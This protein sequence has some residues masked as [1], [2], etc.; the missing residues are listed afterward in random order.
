MHTSLVHP[1]ID[2]ITDALTF[3]VARL[4]ALNERAGGHHFKSKHG[5]TLNQWRVLGLTFAH[6]PVSSRDVRDILYM[7]KGQFSRVVKHLV[8]LGF[9]H[10]TT[11]SQDART[12][13]LT[14]T[15][16]GRKFHDKLLCFT[17]ER[18]EAVVSTLTSQECEEVIRLLDKIS[19]QNEFLQRH[20]GVIS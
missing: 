8:G 20:A 9:I 12:V 11:N 19:A 15:G 16:E 1:P 2:A 7:D 13:E 17:A 6:G 10:T 4:A 3:K 5:I 18:N 14:L